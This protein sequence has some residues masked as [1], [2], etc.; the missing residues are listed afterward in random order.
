M[1][2]SSKF[3]I[4]KH[5]KIPDKLTCCCKATCIPS[6]HHNEVRDMLYTEKLLTTTKGSQ[7]IE[8]Y[9]HATWVVVVVV[10]KHQTIITS[11]L[12]GNPDFSLSLLLVLKEKWFSRFFSFC[13]AC[14]ERR[15]VLS[16]GF[17]PLLLLFYIPTVVCF[18][19]NT[20]SK[21][22]SL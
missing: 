17:L 13:A 19:V 2:N 10:V 3:L 20:I 6:M 4:I 9:L 22:N 15:M 5:T 8:N 21:T 7:I 1:S 18:V 16:Y 14:I 11:W 12:L